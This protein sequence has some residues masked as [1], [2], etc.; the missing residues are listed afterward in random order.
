MVWVAIARWWRRYRIFRA[1]VRR[2]VRS[3]G[4]HAWSAWA[5]VAICV[6]CPVLGLRGPLHVWRVLPRWLL[7][8]VVVRFVA[9]AVAVVLAESRVAVAAWVP[10]VAVVGRVWPGLVIRCRSCP[11]YTIICIRGAWGSRV[12]EVAILVW[13]HVRAAA[14]FSAPLQRH[15]RR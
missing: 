7:L 6:I 14:A 15:M 2:G 10:A 13:R 4:R 8:L 12:R 5:R 1:L 9:V 3:G 11:P